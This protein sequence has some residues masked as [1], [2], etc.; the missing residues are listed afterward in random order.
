MLA[1]W[2]AEVIV[3]D[4]VDAV[5]DEGPMQYGREHVTP[6]EWIEREADRCA[7]EAR[8]AIVAELSYVLDDMRR[9]KETAR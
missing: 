4:F 6:E 1:E 9:L 3:P 8:S 2:I 5:L 7:N